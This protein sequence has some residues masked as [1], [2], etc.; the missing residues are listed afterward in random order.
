MSGKPMDDQERIER[1][2]AS[3][4]SLARA[5]VFPILVLIVSFAPILFLTGQERKLFGPLALT[6]TF[7]LF[8]AML[9]SLTVVPALMAY[10]VKGK[11]RSEARNPVARFFVRL[12]HPILGLCFRWKKA[13][14]AIASPLASRGSQRCRSASSSPPSSACAAP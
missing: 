1:I 6:K 14:V 5:V 13:T 9:V 2:E 10:L 4:R 8:G 3:A 7:V 11:L 12:Y